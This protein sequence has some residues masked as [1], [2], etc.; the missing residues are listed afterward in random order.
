METELQIRVLMRVSQRPFFLFLNEN[1]CCDPSL[2]LFSSNDVLMMGHNFIM[3]IYGK[4]S[5]T[6]LSYT[7][8][9]GV[10]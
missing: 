4:L 1:I 9:S 10:L 2:E 7:F 3:K 5:L 8:L 6:Y